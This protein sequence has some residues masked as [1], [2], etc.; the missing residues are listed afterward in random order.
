MGNGLLDELVSLVDEGQGLLQV[1]DVDAVAVG[2]DEA[3]HLR[4]PTAGLVT[5]VDTSIEQL[6]HSNN[7]HS[8]TGTDLL[9]LIHSDQLIW[10]AVSRPF[11]AFESLGFDGFPTKHSPRILPRDLYLVLADIPGIAVASLDTH[12]FF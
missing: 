12:T 6:A 2:E 3:L 7:S 8:V 5:E 10:F 9:A 1:D 11:L 4:V